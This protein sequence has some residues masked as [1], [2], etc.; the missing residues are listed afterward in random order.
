M[1]GLP[2]SPSSRQEDGGAADRVRRSHN[3][4]YVFEVQGLPMRIVGLFVK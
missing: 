3:W 4:R 2:R 1:C